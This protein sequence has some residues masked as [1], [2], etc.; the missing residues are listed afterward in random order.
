MTCDRSKGLFKIS[1]VAGIV[2][3]ILLLSALAFTGGAF[4][5]LF[6]AAGTAVFFVWMVIAP[7]FAMMAAA[8]Y[9]WRLYAGLKRQNLEYMER[10]VTG[11]THDFNNLLSPVESYAT[12][13]REDLPP[14]S[15]QYGFADKIMKALAGMR[16]LLDAVRENPCRYEEKDGGAER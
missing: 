1:G 6:T 10:L 5:V 15:E 12:F 3:A 4:A 11:L 2:F 14:D 16:R 8:F 7:G 13:L 9:L